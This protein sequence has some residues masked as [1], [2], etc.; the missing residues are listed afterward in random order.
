MIDKVKW[1]KASPEQK[2]DLL[3]D[4]IESIVPT[5]MAASQNSYDRDQK[6]FEAISESVSI[7]KALAADTPG[8]SPGKDHR[9]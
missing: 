2:L 9:M 3:R 7:I 1:A 6:L 5:V 8:D 4:E